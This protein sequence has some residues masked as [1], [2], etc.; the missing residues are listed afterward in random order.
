MVNPTGNVL[1]N[2]I[3]DE[4]LVKI[5]EIK[6]KHERSLTFTPQQLQPVAAS[7]QPNQPQHPSYYNNANFGWQGQEGLE[8]V[9]SIISMLLKK[10]EPT[11]KGATA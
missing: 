6:I 9:H 10:E 11:E 8:A 2:G 5:L 4:E 1:V 3:T 7:T